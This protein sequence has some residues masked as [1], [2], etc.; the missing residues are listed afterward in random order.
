MAQ[1]ELYVPIERFIGALIKKIRAKIEYL[2][3]TMSLCAKWAI[4]CEEDE[5]G[6]RIDYRGDPEG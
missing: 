1:V 4:W 3:H 2:A 6:P 5:G